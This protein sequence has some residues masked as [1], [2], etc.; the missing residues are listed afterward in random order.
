MYQVFTQS[1]SRPVRLDWIMMV[2]W[3]NSQGAGITDPVRSNFIMTVRWRTVVE[4]TVVCIHQTRQDV[5]R[6]G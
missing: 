2:K 3:Y 6:A 5:T 1:E 4:L